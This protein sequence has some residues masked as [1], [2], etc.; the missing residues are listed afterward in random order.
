MPA[1]AGRRHARRSHP[2][3]YRARTSRRTLRPLRLGQGD[4]RRAHRE[5]VRWPLAR[6]QGRPRAA[7]SCC[8]S[9]PTASLTGFTGSAGSRCA[10]V[11]RPPS[12]AGRRHEQ[13]SRSATAERR[14]GERCGRTG[15]RSR[16]YCSDACRRCDDL[17]RKI[18]AGLAKS[19]PSPTP[20]R[21]RR[22]EL[23]SSAPTPP[24][25]ARTWP[26]SA[27]GG[28]DGRWLPP[29]RSRSTGRPPP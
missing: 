8:D 28:T 17:W 16:R 21:S 7:A 29:A 10:P 19:R 20:A 11:G 2:V 12:S 3:A 18:E 26:G 23:T 24:T 22:S 1:V 13:S 5:M 27:S 14:A 15:G 25:A 9:A 6:D 4:P